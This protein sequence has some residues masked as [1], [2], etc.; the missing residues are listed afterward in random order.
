MLTELG[1]N[2]NIPYIKRLFKGFS[3]LNYIKPT[4]NAF[5]NRA[6]FFMGL[7]IENIEEK[8]KS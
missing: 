6:T 3:H 2:P 4:E 8:K 1:H 7:S 5:S